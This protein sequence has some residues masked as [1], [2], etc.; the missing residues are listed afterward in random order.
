M[1]CAALCTAGVSCPL[2][3]GPLAPGPWPLPCSLHFTSNPAIMGSFVNG[4][5]LSTLIWL[6]AL[7]VLSVNTYL[8]SHFDVERT[9]QT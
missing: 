9:P 5:G 8:V 2:P 6:L 1:Q 3:P 4:P 7:A